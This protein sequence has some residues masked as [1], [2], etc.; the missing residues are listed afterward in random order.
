MKGPGPVINIP[1]DV[2]LGS[3]DDGDVFLLGDYD[4]GILVTGDGK[5]TVTP[6]LRYAKGGIFWGPIDSAGVMTQPDFIY[7]V[8]RD[9]GNGITVAGDGSVFVAG[10]V[11]GEFHVGRD[12]VSREEVGEEVDMWRWE[13]D[14]SSHPYKAK[15]Y[16]LDGK[17]APVLAKFAPDGMQAWVRGATPST[18]GRAEVTAISLLSDRSVVAVGT[19]T[20]TLTYRR[21]WTGHILAELKCDAPSASPC[22]FVSKYTWDGRLLWAKG[23]VMGSA[24]QP[25]EGDTPPDAGHLKTLAASTGLLS[26]PL[27]PRVVPLSDDSFWVMGW[28]PITAKAAGGDTDEISRDAAVE[29]TWV[30]LSRFDADGNVINTVRWRASGSAEVTGATAATDDEVVVVGAFSG[31]LGFTPDAPAG[32]LTAAGADDGFAVRI[33][34]SGR[35][36]WT[37]RDGG[38]E[39]D[40]FLGAASIGKSGVLVVG[41]KNVRAR[42]PPSAGPSKASA[43]G[44]LYWYGNDGELM[45]KKQLGGGGRSV[46]ASAVTFPDGTAV[47]AGM[48]AGR[49]Q[50]GDRSLSARGAQDVFVWKISGLPRQTTVE[51]PDAADTVAKPRCAHPLERR[52]PDATLKIR[53]ATTSEAAHFLARYW[54]VNML[55]IGDDNEPI[56]FDTSPKDATAAFSELAAISGLKMV[57]RD[58]LYILGPTENIAR[59]SAANDLKKRGSKHVDMDIMRMEW[60]EI[61]RLFKRLAFSQSGTVEGHVSMLWRNVDMVEIQGTLLALAGA[62]YTIQGDAL[63]LKAPAALPVVSP[64]DRFVWRTNCPDEMF[65]SHALSCVPLSELELIAVSTAQTIPVA[66]LRRRTRGLGYGIVRYTRKGDFVGQLPLD[67]YR[68]LSG[69][70]DP[71]GKVLQVDGDGVDL[72]FGWVNQEVK[73][74]E[75]ILLNNCQ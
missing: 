39:R 36:I 1:S 56:Y 69:R 64:S 68:K 24:M 46:L 9:R 54:H 4:E 75:R 19:Y 23:P 18:S 66:L 65:N 63:V 33:D 22:V 61:A 45:F 28:R 67:T 17:T 13:D 3:T 6:G 57:E 38:A 50:V 2:S 25:A 40:A 37:N 60:R 29:G 7:S 55:V 74:T 59:L 44:V 30:L 52:H 53:G 49:I 14:R 71:L 11:G 73:R 21:Q 26:G 15:S 5:Q 70:I 42:M 8:D 48:F 12:R 51:G 10:R 72:G 34:R 62:S 27:K 35:V 20:E 47:V 41:G 43:V 32:G 58:R 31:G 16:D